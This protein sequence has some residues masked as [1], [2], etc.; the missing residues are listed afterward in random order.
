VLAF[1]GGGLLLA[2]VSLTALVLYRRR[3]FQRRHP[4][5]TIGGSPPELI[6]MERAVLAAGSAGMADVT[7]LDAAL[8]SLVQSI[9]GH[10]GRRLPDVVAARMTETELTLVLTEAAP[11]AP[12]PWQVD[13][14]GTR[15]TIQRE[16]ALPYQASRRDHYFAPFPTLASVGYTPTGEHWLLDL[17]RI[18]AL[19]LSGDAA[20]CLNLIR[21]FAAE[22]AHN[23]WSEML[24]VT[25]VGFGQELVAANPDRLTY[26]E[27]LADAVTRVGGRLDAVNAAM[28]AVDGDV[29][30]GRLHDIAGD[31][32]A[33]TVLLI[34]PHLAADTAGLDD[35][36]AAMKRQPTR[37]SVALVLV[38]DADRG[39][40]TRW[41]MRLD[42][43]G[44]LSIPALGLELIAQQI[45]ADEA[46]QLAQ[47]LAL[48]AVSEDEPIPPAHGDEP[49]DHY[50]DACGGL[51]CLA[52]HASP[53]GLAADLPDASSDDG[54][55]GTVPQRRLGDAAAV[56]ALHL[57]DAAPSTTNSVLPLPPQTYLEHA[58]T[59]VEDLQALAPVVDHR[60]RAKIQQSDPGLD[61]DLTAW[62]DEASPRPKLQL[63]GPVRVSAQGN[64][65]ERSPQVA[66]HTEVVAYL[67][68]RSTGVPSGEYAEMMWPDDPDVVGKPK[69]RQSITI[70]RRWLGSDPQ[71]GQEYLPSGLFEAS[72]ARYRIVGLLCDAE[73]FRRL[74]LRGL[75]RGPDGIEDLWQALQL[76][77]GRPFADLGPRR[78]KAPGGYLWLTEA[79]QR[80]DYEYS[81]MIVDTDHTVATHHFGVG[82]PQRA[83]AAAQV[84]LRGGTYEDV[85][86]LDLVQAC[87]AQEQEAE[88]EAYVRQLLSNSGVEREEDLQ[89]RTAEVLFRLRRRW[90]EHAS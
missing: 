33:P 38:D 14:H 52:E 66:F 47:M 73:L 44:T 76:V 11:T 36:L 20:R 21:F 59:T 28:R 83:A 42:Q 49:W 86:L 7:W 4:G 62:K 43:D 26:T 45:S 34:A 89:P 5:R 31:Q 63:L 18:G 40:P 24:Q 27:N 37:A 12:R 82:E 29:L 9:A 64:L 85:P 88:A 23:S 80:L 10:P 1:T 39:D 71:T 69:V 54:A 53:A 75:S 41:Q 30:D 56:P 19:S 17:E 16:G 90:R 65:P 25:L 13:E 57:A 32:W 81:A 68:T 50:A 70:V 8:R 60:I 55:T 72:T 67:A 58:A 79:N 15:W 2:G 74:R 35:L 87:L 61:A 46:G 3:Q 77:R 78:D 6:G 84:A 48:A 51:T 22:L